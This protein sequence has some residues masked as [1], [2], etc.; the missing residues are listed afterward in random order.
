M[1][2]PPY[3]PSEISRYSLDK[4]LCGNHSQSEKAA[5]QEDKRSNTEARSRVTVTVVK[6]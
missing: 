2:R 1:F 3:T 5:A 6:Q 4:K